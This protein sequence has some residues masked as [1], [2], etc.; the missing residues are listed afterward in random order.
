MKLG[1]GE[2]DP[3]YTLTFE[4]IAAPAIAICIEAALDCN[5][6]IDAAITEA[7]HND[8]TQPTEGTATD[9]TNH[10]TNLPNIEGLLVINPEI[11]IGHIHDH[12]I[13]LQDMNHIDQVHNPA[14]QGKNH[15]PRRT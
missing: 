12:P 7:A 5:T 4:D 10:I 8:L 9:L 14:E 13:G 1:T 6:E 3:D 11:I 15:I 2:T